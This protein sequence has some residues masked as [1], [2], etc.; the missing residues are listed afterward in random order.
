MEFTYE[1]NIPWRFRFTGE[2]PRAKTEL[3]SFGSF[4]RVGDLTY[5][6][7]PNRFYTDASFK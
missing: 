5:S 6:Y 1:E 3:R 4:P 7:F 2:V